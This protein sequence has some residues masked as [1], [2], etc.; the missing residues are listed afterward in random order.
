M[1]TNPTERD[2]IPT[3]RIDEI[4]QA[5]LGP[6]LLEALKGLEIAVE[7]TITFKGKMTLAQ[8]L[9]L[10]VVLGEAGYRLLPLLRGGP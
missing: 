8:L 6:E 2:D 5:K 1:N 4:V 3:T 10:L 9:L 7:A